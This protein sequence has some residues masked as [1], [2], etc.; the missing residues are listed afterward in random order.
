MAPLFCCEGT[1]LWT[2]YVKLAAELE[3]HLLA[4]DHINM[5]N[6]PHVQTLARE[7]SACLAKAS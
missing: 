3:T 5:V 1:E 2:L 7:V 4:G 6:Q